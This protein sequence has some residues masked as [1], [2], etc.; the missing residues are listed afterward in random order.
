MAYLN[1]L[2]SFSVNVREI[3]D[4]HKTLIVMINALHDAMLSNK[5]RETQ[6][7][8]IDTMVRY[9]EVHFKTEEKYMR[10]FDFP[11]YPSHKIEHDQ[12]TAKAVN[13]KERAENDG[14]ILTLEILTFLKE[15]LQNHILG[16]DMR[17][18][19]HFNANGLR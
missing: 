5:G 10:R 17:Y 6:K 14:F 2:D 15:W 1:W 13:L 12:F 19:Q 8:I 3:D 7:T 4:Q 9:A 18:A 11:Y 16:T